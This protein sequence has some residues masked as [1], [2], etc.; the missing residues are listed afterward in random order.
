M[1]RPEQRIE[2]EATL[3]TTPSGESRPLHAVKVEP[4]AKDKPQSKRRGRR[5]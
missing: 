5:A 2:F 1:P 3:A 4:V